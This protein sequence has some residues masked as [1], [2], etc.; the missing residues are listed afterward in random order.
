MLM[1][2]LCSPRPIEHSTGYMPQ[3]YEATI[4]FVASRGSAVV[5]N[6]QYLE[7]VRIV[8]RRGHRRIVPMGPD[9]TAQVSSRTHINRINAQEAP[10]YAT[11]N[12][13]HV[14]P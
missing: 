9:V 7:P 3:Y 8:I 6:P 12:I 1:D 10:G 5:I 4:R 2:R 13:S 14:N 11:N